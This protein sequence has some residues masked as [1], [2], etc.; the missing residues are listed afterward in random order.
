MKREFSIEMYG[1]RLTILLDENM[2]FWSIVGVFIGA[3]SEFI[4]QPEL[5]QEEHDG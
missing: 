2:G 5:E 1:K 4:I 3:L